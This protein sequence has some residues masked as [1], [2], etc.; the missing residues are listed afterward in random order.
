MTYYPRFN[1]GQNKLTPELLNRAMDALQW[2]E[3]NRRRIAF[4]KPDRYEKRPSGGRIFASVGVASSIGDNRWSY[5]WQ[6]VEWNGSDFEPEG[7]ASGG[8][9]QQALNLAEWENTSGIAAYGQSLF[10][11]QGTL[12]VSPIA[13]GSIVVLNPRF[14][15]GVRSW[16][17]EALNPMSPE[18]AP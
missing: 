5:A 14:S 1:S 2:F 11:D 12:T 15:D 16:F 18:C 13:I 4:K 9:E 17:F 10:Y 8:D 3:A 7:L 6:Q